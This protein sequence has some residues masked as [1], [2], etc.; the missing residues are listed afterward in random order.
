M[1]LI[2]HKMCDSLFDE[3]SSY[4]DSSLT[5]LSKI[6]IHIKKHKISIINK[7]L[8]EENADIEAGDKDQETPLHR[9]CQSGNLSIVQYLIEEGANIEAKDYRKRT[10]LHFAY[11]EGYLPIVEYLVKNG[12]NIK[13]YCQQTPL[14]ETKFLYNGDWK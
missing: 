2:Y 4:D 13:D 9:A 11:Q 1:I 10:P 14:F 3:Y 6:G 8:T 12:A 7:Y 5:K